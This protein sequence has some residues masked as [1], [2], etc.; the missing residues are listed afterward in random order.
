MKLQSPFENIPRVLLA[1]GLTGVS[2][3]CVLKSLGWVSFYS[4]YAGDFEKASML[5]NAHLWAVFYAWGSLAFALVA[6]VLLAS[7][8]KASNESLTSTRYLL[9]ALVVLTAICLCVVLIGFWGPIL[10]HKV[11]SV[12]R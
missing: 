2:A 7:R 5:R 1:I 8:I 6:T 3:W 10:H 9:T 11:A 4:A 12:P